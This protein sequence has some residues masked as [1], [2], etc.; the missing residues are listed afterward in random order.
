MGVIYCVVPLDQEIAAYLRGIDVSVPEFQAPSRNPTPRELKDICL[1]QSDLVV[2]ISQPP[3][4]QWQISLNGFGGPDQAP[5]TELNV[6]DFN[7]D[8]SEPHSFSFSKGWPSLIVRLVHLA[9]A[10]CG[11]LVIWPDTGCAP[12][13][14]HA[15]DDAKTLFGSWEHAEGCEYL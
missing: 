13:V 11:P 15:R 9:S 5:W 10:K 3:R 6:S 12:L 14:V 4:N 8:E 2:T 1:A 7:G